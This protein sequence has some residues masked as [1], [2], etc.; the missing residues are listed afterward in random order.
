MLTVDGI[1]V[2]ARGSV[3]DACEEAGAAV[4]RE[5]GATGVCRGCLVEVDGKAKP[6][7]RTPA[8]AGQVVRTDTPALQAYR[9]TWSRLVADEARSPITAAADASHPYLR[10]DLG[11]C[12]LCR[13]CVDV[14]AE[15]EGRFV[16]SVVGRGEETRVSWGHGPFAESP[17]S[18][19]GACAAVCPT[20]AITDV[21]RLR[22]TRDG[23]DRVVRTTCPYCGVGCALDVHVH[24]TQIVRIDGA[25]GG[26]LCGK[27][28]Y[29]HGFVDHPDRLT[30]PLIRQDGE[31]VPVSWEAAIELIVDRFTR[32]APRVAGL[33]SSR[34]T[35]EACYL[36]Q[37][38]IRAGFGSNH[39]DSCA[40]IC[41]APTATGM[42]R[43]FG[44]GAA[45]GSFDDI[46]RSDVLLVAGCNPTEAHP[47]V[48]A[49]L[50]QRV[51][52]GRAK[53]IVIDPRRTD[54]AEVADVHLQL[55]AGT[56]VLLLNAMAHVIVAEELYDRDY[57]A[58]RTEGLDELRAHLADYRPGDVAARCGVSEADIV[59][60]AR[61]WAGAF[62]PLSVHGLGMTEHLQG[63][64]SVM[65]LCNLALL[66]GAVGRPGA[67]MNPLRGQNNVQGAADMGCQPDS[68][69][70]YG[71]IGDPQVHEA[72]HHVWGRPLP[73]S[74]GMT[75]PKMLEAA[76]SGELDAL[77]VVG[78]DL[79]ATEPHR[80]ATVAAL[81]RLPFLVVQ[82]IF[83][84][85]TTPYADVVLPAASAFEKT[86]TFTNGERRIQRIRPVVPSPGQARPDFDILV[87]LS[88]A[89]GL[90]AP[91]TPAAAWGEVGAVCPAKFGGVTHDRLDPHGLQWPV[92][93]TDHPG[94]TT[95]HR[96]AFGAKE[97]TAFAIVPALDPVD[98]PD[99]GHPLRL[100]T[101]RVREHYNTG[102][103][104]RR[105]PNLQ[106]LGEDLCEVHPEDA[107]AR[108]IADGDRVVVSSPRGEAHAVARISERVAPGEMFMSFHFP[109][110]GT[111]AV[112]SDVL[113]RLADCP[114]YKVTAVQLLKEGSP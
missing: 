79:V 26:H 33:A 86:G 13:Q 70:G 104:T 105:T 37:R 29:A 97:R 64:E 92:P 19:C 32:V 110:T 9:R 98:P 38:W 4:P 83:P 103:M 22:A 54:L 66:V 40:R 69:T 101:G 34:C 3:L 50:M 96:H 80:D 61:V 91:A 41:H 57:V 114:E 46:E 107:A 48:G 47:V 60:A 100:V 14:C 23:V 59:R 56:N 52:A 7:C 65:L 85:Q 111:N 20:G 11:A 55:K 2:P 78:E 49:R 113:D 44:T 58:G 89:T 51:L 102:S 87:A 73:D 94:T 39:V 88:E 74:E 93:A 28:R 35:N 24:G 76:A 95:L 62:E 109:D 108:G 30:Q 16:W 43:M 71:R 25:G 82:E 67:G 31:L 12:T 90:L 8:H 10:V 63:T 81:E 42:G 17:C 112:T 5:C 21:D 75:L 15:V 72:C 77:F 99:A 1:Q 6:A 84:S 45:T 68:T 18:G 106:L 53:L 36:L 27:G